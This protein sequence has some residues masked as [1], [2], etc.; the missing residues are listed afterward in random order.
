MEILVKVVQFFLSL[1]LLVTV[2]EIGHFIVSPD[3]KYT[4]YNTNGE[5]LLTTDYMVAMG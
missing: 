2:H 3:G 4:Y 1:T 5:Q